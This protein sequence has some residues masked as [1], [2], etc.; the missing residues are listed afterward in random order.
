MDLEVAPASLTSEE[1]NSSSDR[2]R[3]TMIVLAGQILLRTGHEMCTK[4]SLVTVEQIV[5]P[6][7]APQALT[8][9]SASLAVP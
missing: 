3:R 9:A 4:G 2:G 8:Q 1:G 7:V 6:A 5:C